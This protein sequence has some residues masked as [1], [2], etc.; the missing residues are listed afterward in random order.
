MS[1]SHMHTLP[2]R[3]SSNPRTSP[4]ARTHTHTP[5]HT[6]THSFPFSPALIMF[7]YLTFKVP[8][9]GIFLNSV[10]S[11]YRFGL[12][13]H[14]GLFCL[15]YH[16]VCTLE[17]WLDF[18]KMWWHT[19]HTRQ[20]IFCLIWAPAASSCYFFFFPLLQWNWRVVFEKTVSKSVGKS[21]QML[22]SGYE[23]W[24]EG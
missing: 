4:H 14:S 12:A 18:I 10:K 21:G 7:L 20:E 17:K 11:R 9:I 5:M 23:M 3:G 19:W 6:N 8:E 22:C 24:R 13:V 15:S 16:L 2:T 1:K